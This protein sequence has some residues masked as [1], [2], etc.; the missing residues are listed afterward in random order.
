MSQY[1]KKGPGIGMRCI[2]HLRVEVLKALAS[3]T[4]LQVLD[5]LSASERTVCE[6]ADTLE[7]NQSTISCHLSTLRASGL[8][9]TRKEGTRAYYTIADDTVNQML[10]LLDEM[11]K[12]RCLSD[13]EI[14]ELQDIG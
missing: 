1:I 14:L 9:T 4:R 7:V 2:Y 5:L 6:M 13:S 8:V 11:L 12:S 10:Q 3:H